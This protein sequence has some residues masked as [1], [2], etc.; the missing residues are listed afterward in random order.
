[1]LVKIIG[2][3]WSHEGEKRHTKRKALKEAFFSH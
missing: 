3:K 1:M 2:L